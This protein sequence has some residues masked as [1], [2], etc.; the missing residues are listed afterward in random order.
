MATRIEE[1][2]F[3]RSATSTESSMATTSEA[4]TT[5]ARGCW[6]AA[7][8]AGAPTSSSCASG[9]ALEELR[10]TRAA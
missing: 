1:S 2:F 6:K 4:A 10:G 9:C 5:R 3:L 8:A 7:S